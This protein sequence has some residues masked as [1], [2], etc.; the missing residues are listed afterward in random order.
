MPTAHSRAPLLS[1][2]LV[3]QVACG[4]PSADPDSTTH[5]PDSTTAEASSTTAPGDT[6]T[7]SDPSTDDGASD[8]STGADLLDPCLAFASDA[9]PLPDCTLVPTYTQLPDTCEVAFASQTSLCVSTGEPLAPEPTTYFA[10]IDGEVRYMVHAQPCVSGPSATPVHFAECT[11][12][13][14]E[15]ELCQCLCG[16]Q[17]CP[18][19]AELQ[20][21]EACGLPSPCGPAPINDTFGA[22]EHDLCVLAALR[23]R[24]PGDYGSYLIGLFADESRVFLDGS[25]QAQLVHRNASDQCF[26]VLNGTWEPA[27][28][29]TLQPPAWFEA[30][31]NDPGMQQTCLFGESWFTDCV[32]QPASCP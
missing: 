22:S 29:C 28:T 25:E 3:G 7:T 27:R 4:Q 14:D 19:D 13:P 31:M 18:Y 16:A 15:P 20:L 1:L 30:C 11:G 17:G 12:A 10:E 24:T 23:D 8:S 5:D 32:E 21:L 2:L 26:S 6:A 9:C